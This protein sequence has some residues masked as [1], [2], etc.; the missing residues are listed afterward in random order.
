MIDE[1]ADLNRSTGRPWSRASIGKAHWPSEWPHFDNLSKGPR[2]PSY[3]T[4]DILSKSQPEFL[5]T[6]LNTTLTR[7]FNFF[8]AQIQ[9]ALNFYFISQSRTMSIC[10]VFRRS[11]RE[12]NCMH[13]MLGD[14]FLL[15]KSELGDH[16][17][18]FPWQSTGVWLKFLASQHLSTWDSDRTVS[19]R[20][21]SIRTPPWPGSIHFL[22][23]QSL[24]SL[25]FYNN[26]AT[27]SQ[28]R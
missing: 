8:G 1:I 20:I 6:P 5:V 9:P 4:V 21:H 2:V 22:W 13:V 18:K 7:L 15:L 12:L 25:P 19:L 26:S 24:R 17:L 10:F 28:F 11:R 27:H 16:L 14:T 23:H 3:T